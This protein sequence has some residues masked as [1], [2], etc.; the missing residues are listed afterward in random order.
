MRTENRAWL[1][2]KI[3]FAWQGMKKGR[4]IN[5]NSGFERNVSDFSL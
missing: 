2:G 5:K 1:E 4:K 3:G